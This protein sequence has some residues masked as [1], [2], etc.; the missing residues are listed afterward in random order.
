MVITVSPTIRSEDVPSSMA[1]RGRG[2][3]DL[4]HRQ[5]HD[6]VELEQPGRVA[7]PV[8]ELHHDPLDL[9][10]DVMVGQDVAPAVDQRRRSPSR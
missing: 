3:I 5:V 7:R 9:V 10:H 1:A 4:E 6:R 2:G 8:E